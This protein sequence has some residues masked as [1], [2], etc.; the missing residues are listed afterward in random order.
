MQ[1]RGVGQR[2]GGT[3][4]EVQVNA[5]PAHFLDWDKPLSQ[6]SPHVQEALGKIGHGSGYQVVG[7]NGLVP[8]F[9]STVEAAATAAKSVDGAK[10]I[11]SVDPVGSEVYQNVGRWASD[12]PQAFPDTRGYTAGLGSLTAERLQAA[13]I[14]GIRYLDGGSRADGK[15]TSNHVI[16]DPASIEILRKYGIAGLMAGAAGAAAS[17]Q[18]AAPQQ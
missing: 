5:D 7:P 4:Y 18:S 9:H 14:P 10:G 11:R 1:A 3:M 12:N 15:G 16:F 6:Q 17:G 8:G 13:G 2:P